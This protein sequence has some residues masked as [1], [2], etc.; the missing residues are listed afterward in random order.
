MQ[1]RVAGH[2][3]FGEDAERR[4][5]DELRDLLEVALVFLLAVGQGRRIEAAGDGAAAPRRPRLTE[6]SAMKASHHSASACARSA[7]VAS[8]AGSFSAKA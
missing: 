1:H 6:N 7:S 5:A 3:A 8:S 2:G 4:E